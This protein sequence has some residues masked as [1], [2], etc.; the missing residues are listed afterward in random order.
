LVRDFRLTL[1]NGEL[2][3]RVLLSRKLVRAPQKRVMRY[4]TK[5]R[6]IDELNWHAL[7]NCESGN[8]PRAYSPSGPYY[9]LYQFSMATW[10]GVGG[11]GDPRDASS[12][13]Q[14][15][16]AQ[17]LYKR[18]GAGAWPVCGQRLYDD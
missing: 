2:T 14:T 7:A 3:K 12:S 13:E 6:P 4:G 9:G 18:Q 16:R 1:V 10:Q 5:P 17:L 8:N 15:Y 11:R